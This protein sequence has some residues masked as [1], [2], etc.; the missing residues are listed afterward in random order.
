MSANIF[1]GRPFLHCI[2]PYLP[3]F[4]L[5]QTTNPNH[6]PHGVAD[7]IIT[8]HITLI[9]SRLTWARGYQTSLDLPMAITYA[10]TL[11]KEQSVAYCKTAVS[12]VHEHWRHYILAQCHYNDFSFLAKFEIYMKNIWMLT[13]NWFKWYNW[14]YIPYDS[15]LNNHHNFPKIF[16][17]FVFRKQYAMPANMIYVQLLLQLSNMISSYYVYDNFIHIYVILLEIY[18]TECTLHEPI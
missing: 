10:A 18:I 17:H 3:Q 13:I 12:S 14:L 16:R 8:N 2:S 1:F 4:T 7:E 6:E 11:A 15:I 9:T 5:L